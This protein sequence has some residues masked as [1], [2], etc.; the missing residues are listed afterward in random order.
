MAHKAGYT[1][2]SSHRSGETEDTTIADLAVALNTC[3]IK[4][5]APNAGMFSSLLRVIDYIVN[6]AKEIFALKPMDIEGKDMKPES[7]DIDVENVFFSYEEKTIIDNL[8]VHIPA[9]TTTAIVGPSGGGKTTLCHLIA[10]IWDVDKG[11][12]KLGGGKECKG[13]QYGF[14]YAE[15]QFCI[16]KCVFVLGYHSKQYSLRTAGGFHGTGD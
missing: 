11:E 13:L 14:P 6:E 9:R 4:T 7:F 8:S 1:A 5:G 2:V 16:P 12:V 10:R 15:F 3:Q